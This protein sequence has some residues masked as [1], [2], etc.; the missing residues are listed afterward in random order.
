MFLG[1]PEKHPKMIFFPIK[2]CRITKFRRYRGRGVGR[3]AEKIYDV[4]FN[5]PPVAGDPL[6]LSRQKGLFL[7]V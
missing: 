7:A 6:V 2:T 3:L 1:N 4:F 5:V